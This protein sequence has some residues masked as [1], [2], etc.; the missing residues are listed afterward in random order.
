MMSQT[1]DTLVVKKDN[2]LIYFFQKERKTDTLDTNNRFY[3][4]VSDSLKKDLLIQSENAQL[5]V[6][7]EDS[8]VT[9][10]KMQGMNYEAWYIKEDDSNKRSA[11]KLVLKSFVNGSNS[12]QY[13]KMTIRFFSKKEGRLLFENTYFFRN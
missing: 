9:L 8:L 6:T 13:N 3:L 1:V 11:T 7:R 10:V 2:T 5:R 4:I 12:L